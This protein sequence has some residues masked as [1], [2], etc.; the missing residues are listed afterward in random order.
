VLAAVMGGCSDAKSPKMSYESFSGLAKSELRPDEGQGPGEGGDKYAH[1][2]ENPFLKAADAPLSTFA[3]DVD[4]TSYSKTRM[5]L[6]EH[7]TLPPPDAVRIEELL[8]Y[9]TYDYAGPTGEHPFAANL[10]VAQCPWQAEHALVRIGIKGR[11]IDQGKRPAS[12]LVFLIDVSGS[13]SPPNKLPLVRRGLKMLVDELGE[14]DRV[15]L[16][17]YAGAA[18][19]VLPSTPCSEKSRI[20]AALDRLAAGGSTNGGE[21]IRLA[22]QTARAHFIPGGT[23]RVVLCTDGDF[24]VGTTSTGD[25]VRLA[26][27][28]AKHGVKI[29][30]LGFGMGNHNDAMLEELSNKAD[31]NYFFIDTEHEARKVLVQQMSATLVT[32]AK[33][34]KIQVEFNPARVAAYRLIGYENRLLAAQDFNDDQRDAG[35]IGAGH[36]VTALYEIVPAGGKTEV[37]LPSIDDLKYQTKGQLSKAAGSD[38]L[39]TLKLR[40]QPPEGGK[41]TLIEMA[42]K[43]GA[44]PLDKASADFRFAA[45]VAEFGL[46]LRNSAHKGDANYDAVLEIATETAQGDKTGYRQEF[47]ELVRAAKELKRG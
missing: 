4:T 37:Q 11:E 2:V 18:G 32:I 42:A 3:I 27:Q 45:A 40:Y 30:V 5:Y 19:M 12:N 35:E 13:M 24:N 41:S 26:E 31:G 23:N 43:S 7:R 29:S 20:V 1:I 46:L 9:F 22:Y 14:D 44:K 28:N 17:V 15:A 21:G 39:L 25:L 6:L 10:E 16:V 38:E 33:D 8:N 47:L 34:V 36:T